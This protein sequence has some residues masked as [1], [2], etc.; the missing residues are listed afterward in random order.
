[1]MVKCNCTSCS[2]HLEFDEE[3]LGVT[4]QCPHCGSEVEL[5]ISAPS[6]QTSDKTSSSADDLAL[7]GDGGSYFVKATADTQFVAELSSEQ[8]RRQF[9]AGE[10]HPDW[11]VTENATRSSYSDFCKSGYA[12]VARWL[13]V[14]EFVNARPVP[15]GETVPRVTALL[16]QPNKMSTGECQ[17]TVNKSSPI[18]ALAV[19]VAIVAIGAVTVSFF[20]TRSDPVKELRAIQEIFADKIVQGKMTFQLDIQKSDSLLT[21]FLGKITYLDSRPEPFEHEINLRYQD[22]KWIVKSSRSR[23]HWKGEM[24]PSPWIAGPSEEMRWNRAINEYY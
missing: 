20:V 15:K 12:P 7:T 16:I 11:L 18:H 19:V 10:L 9:N 4:I 22:G 14:S 2:G 24:G 8:I 6:S 1:M 17:P 23:I 21:P 13:T 3:H 5:Y